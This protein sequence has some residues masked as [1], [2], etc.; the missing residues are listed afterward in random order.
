MRA[1]RAGRLAEGQR[2]AIRASFFPKKSFSARV[3][4]RES[5]TAGV[6]PELRTIRLASKAHGLTLRLS[7][8]PW[9]CHW[10]RQRWIP[11]SARSS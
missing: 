6:C 11:A 9:R 3:P 8:S 4:V 2:C 1:S 5:G 7:P 10:T